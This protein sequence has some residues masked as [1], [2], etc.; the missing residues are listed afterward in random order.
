MKLHLTRSIL[1]SLLQAG[2]KSPALRADAVRYSRDITIDSDHLPAEDVKIIRRVCSG[3]DFADDPRAKKL[4]NKLKAAEKAAELDQDDKVNKL[5]V[6]AVVLKKMIT[7][8]P[9]HWLFRED[10]DNLVPWYVA[11]IEYSPPEHSRG[12]STPACTSIEL[13]AMVRGDRETS[14]ISFHQADLPDTPGE[15]LKSAGAFMAT[16]AMIAD[17]EKEQVLYAEIADQTGEQFLAVGMGEV[18]EDTDT[19]KEYHHRW[20]RGESRR[21]FS[22]DDVPVRVIMDDEEDRD[23]DSG[24]ADRAFWTG[25]KGKE[26]DDGEEEEVE[27]LPVHPILRVFNLSTHEF[28]EGHISC[29]RPYDYDP[30]LIDKLVLPAESRFLID[31]LT[32]GTVRR[33]GDIV[34]GKA[35]GIMLLCSG[36]PGTGKTLTAETYSEAA[37]RPLYVV[38]CSQLGTDE[39]ELEKHLSVVL[40]R[41]TRWRAIMLID[42]ADVYIHE[43]GADIQQNAIVGVFLR[44]L[45]YY[46][47]ILFLTTNRATIIDDAILSRMTAHVRYRLPEGDDRD[48]LWRILFENFKIKAPDP[49]VAD[50]IEAFPKASG[51]MMRQ[52]IRLALFMS[53]AAKLPMSI[54]MLKRASAFHGDRQPP[55]MK[56]TP[57]A[58]SASL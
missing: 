4:L 25:R 6:L 5:E 31:A 9:R 48:R 11:D 50:C 15:L 30:K 54:E 43:R 24:V 17:Y 22:K 44:L 52:L 33:M 35:A 56:A 19:P 8:A 39:A 18:G 45:E 20:W 10:G 36:E 46:N 23:E 3:G 26:G 42:E 51:R 29:F 53:T 38:Q 49:L 14:R 12:G 37:R 32:S 7:P 57:K 47:G 2:V 21:Y 40:K 27:M 28:V 1:D 58:G 16:D 41:A 34:R 55:V 13:V